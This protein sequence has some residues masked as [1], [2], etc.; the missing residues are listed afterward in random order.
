MLGNLLRRSHSIPSA[1][2]DLIHQLSQDSSR[3]VQSYVHVVD[4]SPVSDEGIS[5][6]NDKQWQKRQLRTSTFSRPPPPKD[7]SSSISPL[8][9]S[10]GHGT[11][12]TCY[13][14]DYLD[15]K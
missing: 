8:L 6:A 9:K 4:L 15:T 14:W 3:E 10:C 12:S 13:K 1:L 2:H 7:D 11:I 5:L